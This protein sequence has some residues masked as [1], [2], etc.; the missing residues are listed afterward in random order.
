MKSID[1]GQTITILANVGVIA[2]LIFLGYELHQNNEFL[3]QQERYT[4]LQNVVGFTEF[5]ADEDKARQDCYT[6]LPSHARF[7]NS[8]RGDVVRW[9]LDYCTDGNGNSTIWRS[10]PTER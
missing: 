10:R 6:E 8:M 3:E 5:S 9:Y 7:R 1:L 4:F 2:G